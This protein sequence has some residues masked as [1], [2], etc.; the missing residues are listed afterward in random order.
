MSFFEAV[1]P[2]FPTIPCKFHCDLSGPTPVWLCLHACVSFLQ[3]GLTQQISD[4]WSVPCSMRLATLMLFQTN[5]LLVRVDTDSGHGAGKPT[6]KIVSVCR[7]SVS[8]A[9]SL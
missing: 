6:A 2:S 8:L 1:V 7:Q 3:L 4:M 5:P 9:A